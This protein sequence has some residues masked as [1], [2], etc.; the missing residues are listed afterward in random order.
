MNDLLAEFD[1]VV[2]MLHED[3]IRYAVVGGLAVAVY[4]GARATRDMDF[5]V[6]PD[7]MAELAGGLER[8]GYQ[9]GHSWQ[10]KKSSLMIH[11][12]WKTRGRG[13]DLSI[14]DILE[15]ESRTYTG[16]LARARNEK[17]RKGLTLCVVQR[18]DLIRLK[19]GRK[20]HTD[21]ADIEFLEGR[22]SDE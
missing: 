21:R 1:Q 11:R 13:E 16:M 5:L 4:G 18:Q 2:R 7:D 12:W 9:K 3:R 19:T 6:H 14:V 20:S 17:W 10:F 8:L 15:S 22:G